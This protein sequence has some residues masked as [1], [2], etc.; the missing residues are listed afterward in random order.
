M[1]ISHTLKY[2]FMKHEIEKKNRNHPFDTREAECF[3]LAPNA[4]DE[5]NNSYY[6]SAHGTDGQSMFFRYAERGQKI[7]EVWFAYFVSNR[8]VYA[9]DKDVFVAQDC[10]ATVRC[11]EPGERWDFTYHTDD[12]DFHGVFD[13]SEPLFDFTYHADAASLA[14]ALAK[15]KWSKSFFSGLRSNSQSHQEQQGTIRSTLVFGGKTFEMDAIAIRDHS[16]GHRVWSYMNRHVWVMALLDDGNALNASF[17]S[18]PYIKEL[19][20]GYFNQQGNACK[21]IRSLTP[22]KQ[23]DASGTF[24]FAA[25]FSDG[26]SVDI[27]CRKTAGVDYQ[28][29]KGAYTLNEGVADFVVGGIHGR[30]IVEFGFNGDRNRY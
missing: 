9:N 20:S 30:G 29:E 11:V 6:F 4:D 12:L 3:R 15:E 23:L 14:D 21:T 18:Y 24:S 28:F 27:H 25:R 10:P 17:V 8:L 26:S 7:R 16:Y 1:H 13:A 5:Q 22:M 19:Q 2:A